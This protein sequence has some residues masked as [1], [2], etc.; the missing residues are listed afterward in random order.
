MKRAIFGKALSEM[1]FL[2]HLEELRWRIIWSLAAVVV[3]TAIG[4][5]LVERFDV[6][7]LL[8]RPI[9]PFLVDSKLKYLNPIDPFIITLKL[10]VVVGLI[11]AF[12][13][14]V[15]QV[16][17]FLSPALTRREH[18]VIVPSLYFGLLLFLAGVALAYF[19]V[20]PLA[21]EFSMGFQQESLE[22][23]IVIGE[24]LSFTIK[25]L[26]AF[27]I[28]FELPIVILVLSV[29]G[30]VTPE[31]LRAQRRWAIVIITIG[32]ALITPPDLV[33]QIMMMIP[34]LFLYEVSIW[35]SALVTRRRSEEPAAEGRA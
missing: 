2:D 1:P 29:L 12:P 35:L 23:S 9:D 15:Y 8:I 28:V 10:A 24:Y 17:T 19:A 32:S 34:M 31:F 11:L 26:L 7:G 5:F 33:S 18:R 20:L 16:W 25:L 13:I 6:L 21:L 30:L 3:G 14:V 22:Q 27:G 4:Y